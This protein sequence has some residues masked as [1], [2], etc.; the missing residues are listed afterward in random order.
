MVVPY[1]NIYSY[2]VPHILVANNM[3]SKIEYIHWTLSQYKISPTSST[4]LK[5]Y[6]RISSYTSRLSN[7]ISSLR[8]SP[9]ISFTSTCFSVSLQQVLS[10]SSLPEKS[11]L[12]FSI[13]QQNP[14]LP[15]WLPG[16]LQGPT[17]PIPGV[18]THSHP[19]LKTVSTHFQ[20]Y[21]PKSRPWFTVPGYLRLPILFHC[22]YLVYTI[23]S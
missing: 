9:P 17:H 21:V 2:I 1:W 3:N 12:L 4:E 10:F 23:Q 15:A 13:H 8:R 5:Y 18:H 22:I 7:R 6:I 14:C 19:S 16:H 11:R 20:E